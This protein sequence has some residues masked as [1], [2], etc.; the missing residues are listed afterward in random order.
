MSATI[1]R[2][3]AS[4]RLTLLSAAIVLSVFVISLMVASEATAQCRYQSHCT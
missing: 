2:S 4:D 1:D 3:N